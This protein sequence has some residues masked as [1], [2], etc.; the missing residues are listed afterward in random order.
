MKQVQLSMTLEQAEVVKHALDLYSR[1]GSGQI[2]EIEYVLKRQFGFDRKKDILEGESDEID[3]RDFEDNIKRAKHAIG[4]SGNASYGVGNP[5]LSIAVH[6]SYEIYKGLCYA[7]AIDQ[8]PNPS[9]KTVDYDGNLLRY[10]QD[11]EPIINI[12]D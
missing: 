5:R 9:F 8:N 1:I 4:L 6:R 11:P 2:E 12:V 7:L 3:W 10:T